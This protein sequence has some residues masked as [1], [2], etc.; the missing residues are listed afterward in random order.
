M[1]SEDYLSKRV[2]DQIHW[3]DEKATK[4]QKEYKKYQRIELVAATSIP[5]LSGFAVGNIQVAIIIGLLGAVVAVVEGLT[6]LDRSHEKWIEYRATCELLRNEKYLYI[7]GSGP[8]MNSDETNFHVFVETIE[9]M[10][11]SENN[12]WKQVNSQKQ[13]TCKHHSAGS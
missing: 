9:R 12:K 1:T 5:L 2:E 11:S 6:K 4:A 13:E 10:V 8:Y 3:Y 7:T